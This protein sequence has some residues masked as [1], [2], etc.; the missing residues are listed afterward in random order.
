MD[1][2]ASECA[3][4]SGEP[5]EFTRRGRIP[6]TARRFTLANAINAALGN[7]GKTVVLAGGMQTSEGTFTEL[8]DALNARQVRDAG[9]P[10]WATR[11]TT[12]RRIWIGPRTQR[13]PRRSCASAT[14]KTK[15]RRRG[16]WHL[17]AAH[18]LESWG[19]ART[20]D[21]T[22]VPVQPLIEPLFGGVTEL[23]VLARIGWRGQ[24]QPYEIVARDFPSSRGSDDVE[25]V[26]KQVF[27]R[28]FSGR[29]P[30][31][32]WMRKFDSAEPRR[33][34]PQS[35]AD[36]RRRQNARSCFP[37]RLQRGRRPLQQQWLAAGDAR[38]RSQDD[39]GQRRADQP[40]DG[41]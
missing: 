24:D 5:R 16:D 35:S 31:P 38:S 10:R 2:W 12:R 21:G 8:A 41:R 7:V 34:S 33:R 29:T 15:L 9:N 11:F 26:W 3:R 14:T 28:R 13:K 17:P 18:Y 22:L 19:D 37:S 30:R 36:R 40:Q 32:R 23:E 25:A 1:S 27:A 4:I 6:P 39:L 20:S